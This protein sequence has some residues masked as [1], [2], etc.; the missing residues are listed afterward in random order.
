VLSVVAIILLMSAALVAWYELAHGGRVYTGVSVLGR[1]LGGMSRDEAA[2]AITSA[3]AG[4]PA[5]SVAVSGAGGHW[6]FSAADLAVGV[7]VPATAG[8]ALSVGRNGNFFDN[9]ATQLRVLLG[10]ARVTP[11]LHY[12]SATVDKAAA[13]VA[14]DVDKP[15]VDSKL[16][17]NSDGMAELTASAQ[18]V[19][20]D[21]SVLARA[22]SAAVA[23]VPFGAVEVKAIPVAPKVTEAALQD[24]KAQAELLT[25]QQVVLHS[26]KQSWTIQPDDLRNLLTIV[27]SADG[28]AQAALD[29]NELALYLQPI[30]DALRIDPQDATLKVGDGT[31]TLSDD[32]PGQALDAAAAIT[33][34]QQAAQGQD[35]QSRDVTLPVNAVPATVHTQDL[36]PLYDKVNSLVTQGLRLHFADD[37]YILRGSAVTDFLDVKAAQGGPGPLELVIDNNV[38]TDRVAGVAYYINRRPSDARFKMVNGAPTRIASAVQGV[39]V[40]VAKSVEN[41]KQAIEGYK[42][43][44]RLQVELDATLT[45]PAVKDADLASISTPDLLAYGQTSYVGSSAN[46]AWNVEF[47]TAK[48]D[49]ALIPP[50]GIFSTVDT[51]GDLTIAAGFKM[52]YGIVTNG[53]GSID[54]VPTEA[55]GICQ[56]STTLYHAVFHAGLHVVERHWH[57]YWIGIYGIAPTGMMGLD[58][59]IAPPDDDFRF[60]NN[61]GNWVMIKASA[62]KGAVRFELW[63]VNPHWNVSIGQ[64]VISNVVQTSQDPIIET[65]DQLPRSSGKVMVEHAQNGFDASIHRVVTDAQGK[66]IDDWTAKSTYV[67]AH[68]RYLVG[69]G[70]N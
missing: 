8:A 60:Q 61:T 32:V 68:N 33:A 11:E 55:G 56:V 14:G 7:D 45:E 67:P 63:G 69:T 70:A 62:S 35:A 4:Y 41:A 6:T 38:L 31:V 53:D 39:Q 12:D 18:G 27:S 44:D 2:A 24:A 10:G 19:A 25:G 29:N 59:T 65:S 57:E 49:G 37:G 17:K 13:K 30:A 66:V 51:M 52:G 64:P 48:F 43:G 9:L 34:I 47:G 5:G 46:R 42:G 28:G 54:T 58:A 15:A 16:E 26:G 36:Q 23:Q 40:N 1:E 21:K 50:G 22:L 3:S 20:V